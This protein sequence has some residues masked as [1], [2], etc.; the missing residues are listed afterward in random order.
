MVHSTKAV[1]VTKY[2][3]FEIA[4]VSFSRQALITCGTKLTVE[5]MPATV[6]SAVAHNPPSMRVLSTDHDGDERRSRPRCSLQTATRLQDPSPPPPCYSRVAAPCLSPGR[7]RQPAGRPKG[8][9]YCDRGLVLRLPLPAHG[10]GG[11]G[12]WP[13]GLGDHAGAGPPRRR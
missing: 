11:A 4:S 1:T 13:G 10:A 6:P 3:R 2:M 9:V 12:A 5:Q 8:R 7:F